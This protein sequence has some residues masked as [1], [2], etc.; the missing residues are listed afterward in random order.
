MNEELVKYVISVYL[1]NLG[2]RFYKTS[3]I[4]GSNLVGTLRLKLL[5]WLGKPTRNKRLQGLL[6]WQNGS[7][8][9]FIHFLML[10]VPQWSLMKRTKGLP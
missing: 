10:H 8:I 7:K 3:H 4:G 2:K 1:Y 9:L 6:G 5:I